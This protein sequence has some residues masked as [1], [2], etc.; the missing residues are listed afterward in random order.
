MSEP[1][2]NCFDRRIDE[3]RR[4][5]HDLDY[6]LEG[7]SEHRQFQERREGKERRTT[8]MKVGHWVSVSFVHLVFA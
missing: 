5:V 1:K 2:R 8:W 7:N 3:D 6:F 4:R